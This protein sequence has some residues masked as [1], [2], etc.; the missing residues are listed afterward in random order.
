MDVVAATTRTFHW[1]T[2]RAVDANALS[3]WLLTIAIVAYLGLD[4]GGY[5][6]VVRNQVGIAVWWGVLVCA[7]VGVLPVAWP[8]RAGRVAVALFAGFVV[9]TAVASTWSVSSERSLQDLSQVA[10]YLG[11]FVLGL[12]IHRDRERAIRWT[13]SAVAAAIVIIA[14]AALLSSLRPGTFPSSQQT[15][16]VLPGTRGRLA[17]PLNYWN[18][19][20]ALMALG[21]PLVLAVACS[22]RRIAVQ[23]AAAAAV[24]I[25]ALCAYLTFSRGGEVAAGVGLIAFFALTGE[26]IP[27]LATAL[28][29]AAGSAVLIDGASHRSAIENGLTNATARHQ[30]GQL[31]IELVLVC[32]GTALAQAGVGLAVRHGTTPRWLRVSRSRARLLLAAAIVVGAAIAVAAGAPSRLSHTWQDFKQPYATALAHNQ[33][34]RFGVASGNGRYQLWQAAVDAADKRLVRGWGPGTFAL[35]WPPRASIY[36][37]VQNAHS[38]YLE[39]LAEEGVI[40]L[41]LLVSFLAVVIGGGMWAAARAQYEARTQAAGAFAACAAF[42]VSA[43][44]DWVWQLSVLPCAF[45]LLGAA[46]LAPPKRRAVIRSEAAEAGP[47]PSGGPSS[48][49]RWRVWSAR[50]A[51]VVIA[52]A[53]LLVIA[54]PLAE[55]TALRSSQAAA[56]SGDTAKA[57][58]DAQS[59]ARL[60]PG[61]ASPQLQIALL[62]ETE[63]RLAP[64]IVRAHRATR[65]EPLNWGAWLVLSRLHDEAGHRGQALR[66]FER[67]RSLN[68]LSPIFK[69]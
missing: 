27:K 18:G 65:D 45:L 12:V 53:C 58:S 30:G 22:A 56:A 40:G 47:D 50:G 29:T 63:H 36:N 61:A 23:A 37:P 55:T 54:W 59:A 10:C 41:A 39:T 14:A 28:I 60:E 17:W 48:G 34:G 8:S 6:L 38:L 9:W 68:P 21:L 25:V 5:D 44:V 3:V 15:V 69:L 7:A 62:L 51:I 57:L 66:A 42:V 26:R 64:A 19:L 1:R 43:V 11:L 46:L 32:A 35:L 49:G 13:V 20:A 2:L 67:A 31:L 4:G 33:L 16:A 52:L 24:P